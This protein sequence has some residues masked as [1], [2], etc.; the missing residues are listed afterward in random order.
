VTAA[1]FAAVAF[2]VAYI[3][4]AIREHRACWVAGGIS[5]ALYAAVF[6]DAGLP[7]QAALQLLYVVL[8]VYGWFAWRRAAADAR[9][10]QSWPW[11]RHLAAAATIALATAVSAPLAA[12]YVPAAAPVADSAGTW[13]SVFA[14]WLLARRVVDTWA[15]WV[16]IDAGLAVLF[17]RQ[18]LWPTAALYLAYA[19]LAIAGWR[20]WRVRLQAA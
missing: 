8:S 14:T 3:L 9:P 19:T 12:R 2:G 1:E 17:A 7:M 18:G 16:A 11:P 15:W 10:L 13:A 6:V 5:T 20:A 4:L